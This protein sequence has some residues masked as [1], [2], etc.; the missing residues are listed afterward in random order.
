MIESEAINAEIKD[1]RYLNMKLLEEIKQKSNI[2][3]VC[4]LVDVK[5]NISDVQRTLE[6]FYT[7]LKNE[8]QTGVD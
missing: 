4:A 6:N 3:D 5:A 2:K 7:D 8:F 1:L